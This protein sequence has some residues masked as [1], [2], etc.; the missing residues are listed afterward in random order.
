MLSNEERDGRHSGLKV[1]LQLVAIVEY[2][3]ASA[4]DSSSGSVYS[5]GLYSFSAP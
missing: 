2:L 3:C 5:S 1:L 4:K